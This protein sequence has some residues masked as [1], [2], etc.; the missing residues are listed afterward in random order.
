[1]DINFLGKQVR[2]IEGGTY[3]MT[4]DVSGKYCLPHLSF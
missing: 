1:M 3:P 2:D 4:T